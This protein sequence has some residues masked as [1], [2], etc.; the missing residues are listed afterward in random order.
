M[1]PHYLN[2]HGHTV[3]PGQG[4]VEISDF[5]PDSMKQFPIMVLEAYALLRVLESLA[6]FLDHGR[7]DVHVDNKVLIAA[8]NNEGCKS[9]ELNVALKQIF[10]FTVE[11]DI[12]LNL[13]YVKSAN[14]LAGRTVEI[15]KE[16]RFN[17]Y[18]L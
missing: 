12:F 10:N 14:N 7:V 8:W 4:K 2:G 1:I 18:R 13:I 6:L 3:V 5:W 17:S 15:Y 9:P 11:N 16:H